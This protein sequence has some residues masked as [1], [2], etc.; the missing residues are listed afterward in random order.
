MNYFRKRSSNSLHRRHEINSPVVSEEASPRRGASLGSSSVTP[1]K[2]ERLDKVL[3]RVRITPKKCNSSF[4][5]LGRKRV[6]AESLRNCT[7]KGDDGGKQ[8][9]DK[10]DDQR[11]D[12][13]SSLEIFMDN[14][15][16][17]PDVCF[18]SRLKDRKRSR[19]G[20]HYAFPNVPKIERQP[21]INRFNPGSVSRRTRKNSRPARKSRNDYR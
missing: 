1:V 7:K 14:L 19:V 12:S 10:H 20:D 3:Q 15:K 11:S 5:I 13:N 17:S 16:I 9:V 2:E 6:K 8:R 18:V 21:E 4:P